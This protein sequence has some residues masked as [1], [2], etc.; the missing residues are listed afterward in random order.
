TDEGGRVRD[1]GY[2][3]YGRLISAT[4][5]AGES[6]TYI[7]G[8]NGLESVSDAEGVG[9]TLGYNTI[10]RVANLSFSDGSGKS[11]TYDE[12]RNLATVTLAS[13]I[14]K[15]LGYDLMGRLVSDIRSTGE[16]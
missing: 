2:D 5:F 8:P 15:T 4:D 11:L 16:Q 13:G 12:R 6:A 14:N 7:W 3:S 1:Y 9:F 10:G